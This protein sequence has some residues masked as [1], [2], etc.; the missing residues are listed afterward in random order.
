MKIAIHQT[1]GSYS[2]RWI[3]Y[4]QKKEINYKIVNCYDSD[5][6]AQLKDCDGLMWH[7]YHYDYKAKL[8]ARQLIYSIEKMGIKVFPDSNTC[9]HFDDKV[10][11]KY[12]LEGIGAPL[13]NSYVFYDKKTAF[14]WI[15]KTKFPKVFKLRGGAGSLNV[16]L[17]KS[18][19][20]AVKLVNKAFG[21]GFPQSD[22][23]E[24]LKD[25]WGKLLRKKDKKSLYVLIR[26][27]AL[28]FIPGLSVNSKMS[29]KEKGYVY[30][31][32]FVPNNKFDDRIV[33]VGDKAFALRRFV[34]KNDFRASGSGEFAYNRTLFNINTIKIAF[35]IADKIQSQSIAF[36]FVYDDTITKIVEIS[37][38][39]SMGAA[40]DNC[41]G[42]WDRNLNWHDE[43]VNPQIFMIEDFLD[44][45][46]RG[47]NN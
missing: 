8:F 6:I 7:W 36:D 31:Q 33:I 16:K 29:V 30:F 34:R 19:N 4:C 17:I 26:G 27:L 21:R 47:N 37:Y 5:I 1:K 18:R 10:G 2:D 35:E 3:E 13:V 32:D 44:R 20:E 22:N 11:Q 15:N 25:R 9:W 41:H 23:K 24:K 38:A 14:A 12:L 39:Y 45:I 46:K 28:F 42:Y 40:Y 43:P